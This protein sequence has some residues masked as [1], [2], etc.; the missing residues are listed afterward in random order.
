MI[1]EDLNNLASPAQPKRLAPI[2]TVVAAHPLISAIIGVV[3]TLAGALLTVA[4]SPD[5]I[6]LVAAN[7]RIT[8]LEGRLEKVQFENN[9]LTRSMQET[10]EKLRAA[11]NP[12]PFDAAFEQ[13]TIPV[14]SSMSIMQNAYF[15]E[16]RSIR[17]KV[18]GLTLKNMDGASDEVYLSKGS[19]IVRKKRDAEC[20]MNVIDVTDDAMTATTSCKGLGK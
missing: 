10:E 16:L 19:Q 6:A 15:A 20:V 3:G 2:I 4:L 8:V 1:D 5:S 18:A 7:Q 12:R 14:G 11:L 13:F 9:A 17:G